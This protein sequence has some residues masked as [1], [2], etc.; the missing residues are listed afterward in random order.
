MGHLINSTAVRLGWFSNWVDSWYSD[1]V[2]YSEFLYN[3][4]RIRLFLTYFFS[5]KRIEKMGFFFSHCEIIQHHYL[6][7]NI[8]LYDGWMESFLD[9]LFFEH[10]NQ[11]QELMD[12]TVISRSIS[13][14]DSWLLLMLFSLTTDIWCL[15][16]I[17][18]R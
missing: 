5:M 15:P 8:Y 13:S 16:G 4:I 2:Y 14:Y 10:F 11:A 3:V 9:T 18:Q 1:H 6:N 12:R 7:V 17:K